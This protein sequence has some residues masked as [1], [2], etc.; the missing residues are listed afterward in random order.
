MNINVTPIPI[1]HDRTAAARAK[2]YRER[3]HA[4]TTKIISCA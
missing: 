1:R 3:R 4:V 2:R